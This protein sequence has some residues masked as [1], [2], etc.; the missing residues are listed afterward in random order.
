MS[1]APTTAAAVVSTGGYSAGAQIPFTQTFV[2]TNSAGSTFTTAIG[3]V[4]QVLDNGHTN[5][6]GYNQGSADYLLQTSAPGAEHTTLA[7]GQIFYVSSGKAPAGYL[8]TPT[9]QSSDHGSTG[10]S[11]GPSATG[12]SSDSSQMPTASGTST[13]G[14]ATDG[15][16]SSTASAATTSSTKPSSGYKSSPSLV[17]SVTVGLLAILGIGA[18]Y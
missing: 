2:Q 9:G 8:A 14:S 3:L 6:V 17:L 16:S 5:W 15:S 7:N 18:L 13:S 12:S 4:G 1:S 10:T 11:T